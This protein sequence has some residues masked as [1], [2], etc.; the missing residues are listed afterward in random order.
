MK[1]KCVLVACMVSI[2]PCAAWGYDE[3]R[4]A[5][6]F[7][8]ELVECAAYFNIGAEG[9]RR[10]G[11]KEAANVLDKSEEKAIDIANKYSRDDVILARYKMAYEAHLKKI[12]GNLSNMSL[13]IIEYKDI[14]KEA[15]EDPI[16]RLNY[17]KQKK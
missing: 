10:G 1:I 15:I 7:S 3:E 14:C 12:D 2:L 6:N 5:N 16:G 13:L 8:H 11:H 4:A 17:W 9:A